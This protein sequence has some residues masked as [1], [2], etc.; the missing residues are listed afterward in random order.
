MTQSIM[1]VKEL[2]LE[3]QIP[4]MIDEL[5]ALGQVLNFPV[6]QLLC[7]PAMTAMTIIPLLYYWED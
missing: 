2:V 7:E 1:V 4:T 6:L 3:V 5:C